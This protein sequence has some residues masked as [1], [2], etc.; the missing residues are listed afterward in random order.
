MKYGKTNIV[1]GFIGLIIAI[2]GGMLLGLTFDQYAVKNSEHVLSIVRFYLREG[3]SHGM[4]I[5]LYN[6]LIGLL[7][8]KMV[9]SDR[10]KMMGSY[11]AI[12]SFALPIFLAAKGAS[13]APTL[14]PVGMI[15]VIGMLGST[16]IMLIGTIRIPR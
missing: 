6:L 16:I 13:G 1:A 15:G 7:I 12:L 3:H 4:P 11:L 8:D 9:L 2:I 5:A 10:I 14:P